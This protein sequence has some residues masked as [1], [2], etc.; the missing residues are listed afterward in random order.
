MNRNK[1]TNVFYFEPGGT[2]TKTLLHWVQLYRSHKQTK[3]DYGKKKNREI[4]GQDNPPAYDIEKLKNYNVKS[5]M[6]LSDNDSFSYPKDVM[7]FINLVPE[8]RRKQIFTIKV[9]LINKN[10]IELD[11]L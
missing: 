3:F 4:Y 1:L 5:Y 7:D 8:E 11:G 10:F 6:T 2:S 9:E